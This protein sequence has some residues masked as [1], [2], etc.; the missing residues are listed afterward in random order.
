MF[1]SNLKIKI[2]LPLL[3]VGFALVGMT[4]VAAVSA[5]QTRASLGAIAMNRLEAAAELRAHELER[6]LAGIEG[7]LTSLAESPSTLDALSEFD[8]AFQALER[9]G[10]ATTAL[11]RAYIT[12]NPNPL[13]EKHRLDAA[14]GGTEYDAV[15]ARYHPWMR[16]HLEARGYYDMFLFNT[17]GD[18][19]YS[20]FKE[21]DFATNF[22]EGGGEWAA[23]DLGR[24]FRAGMA[25]REGR[26]AF[27]DFAPYAPSHGAPASFIA[28]PLFENGA[29]VG[30][31]VFQMPIDAINTIMSEDGGLGASGET[32]LIGADGLLRNDSRLT[33]GNDIL[34]ARLNLDIAQDAVASGRR[35]STA[36]ARFGER[37][38]GAAV[39]ALEF[40]GVRWA[41]AAVQDTAEKNA[42]VNALLWGA[43]LTLLIGSALFAALGYLASTTLTGPLGRVIEALDAVTAGRTSAQADAEARRGDEI[44]ALARAVEGF[45]RNLIQQKHM[46]AEQRSRDD[47]D[48]R[49]QAELE[50]LVREFQAA[51]SEVMETVNGEVGRMA[52]AADEVSAV[53][54]GANASAEESTAAS[55]RA[56]E[57]VA[58]VSA[59]AQELAASIGE[60]ARQ[61]ETATTTVSETV[62]L[63]ERTDAQVKQLSEAAQRISEVVDLINAIAEQTNLLAL[64][65][66]IEAARAGDAGKGFA[67]VAQEVKALAEQ[68]SRATGDIAAQISSVQ[69]STGGAVEALAEITSSIRRVEEV[70]GAIAT[71]IEEQNAVTNEISS[72]ITTASDGTQRSASETG[73]AA[74]AI[75]TTA[76]K[77]GEVREAAS[78]LGG[79]RSRLQETIDRFLAAVACDVEDR[80]DDIRLDVQEAVVIDESGRQVSAVASNLS[81]T[82]AFVEGVDHLGEGARVTLK[83]Q[84][85][86]AVR[87]RVVRCTGHGLGLEFETPLARL[88]GVL[89][90]AA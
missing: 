79:A 31:L 50:A 35:G 25:A 62:R 78:T 15:H 74:E 76:A 72:A 52:S 27:F 70:S 53:S 51:V 60:I 9:A 55:E 29:R 3:I 84:D 11:K 10:D 46:Q 85:R 22:R 68:T 49:R 90:A 5:L 43:M 34:Q 12:D 45:Q 40:G 37:Q 28:T 82:G 88:P 42:P 1:W 56:S 81:L 58:A 8:A 47:I 83:F 75:S 66:T 36:S 17:G 41:V 7:D 32:L 26:T 39:T 4:A 44:G 21:E 59:A 77:A 73:R 57:A 13:G 23:S 67:V 65:A 87:A 19:V 14:P 54:A 80:R 89:G 64:N 63:T 2:K 61:T 24:A 6:Y 30:V 69:Q 33:E 18:L 71:A 86:T 38:V 48:R 16:A 20:V